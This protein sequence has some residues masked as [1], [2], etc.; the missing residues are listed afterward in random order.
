MV[1]TIGWKGF[2]SF[3]SLGFI[4]GNGYPY[5]SSFTYGASGSGGNSVNLL[6][7]DTIYECLPGFIK[8]Q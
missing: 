8:S 5:L 3:G 2:A 1:E 4:I 7:Y 6:S